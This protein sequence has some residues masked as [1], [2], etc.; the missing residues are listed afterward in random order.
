MP[1]R[2]GGEAVARACM[3]AL[4]TLS[5]GCTECWVLN[6]GCTTTHCFK[7]CVLKWNLP[8]NSANNPG[9]DGS[10]S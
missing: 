3:Q 7:E 10:A 8:T 5:V 2:P 6:M 1:L 4:T 9:G